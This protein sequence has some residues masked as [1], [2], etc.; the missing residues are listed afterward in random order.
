MSHYIHIHVLDPAQLPPLLRAIRGALFPNN[1]PGV[2]SLKPPSS[3]EQLAALRRRCA[4]ALWGLLPKGVGELYYGT[5]G[6]ASSGVEASIITNRSASLR[7]GP[8]RSSTLD[9]NI[10]DNLSGDTGEAALRVPLDESKPAVQNDATLS[11]RPKGHSQEPNGLNRTTSDYESADE[12]KKL[13]DIEN[14]IVDIFSD[15]YYNKHL[16][17]GVLELVLVRL[18]PELTERGVGALWEERLV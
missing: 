14:G 7:A 6:W 13:S 17:Y 18:V 4:S 2:S 9:Y 15:A 11:S 10:A 1:A 5:S 12:A 3:D 8:L 16:I